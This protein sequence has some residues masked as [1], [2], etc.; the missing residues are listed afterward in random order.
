[1]YLQR[2]ELHGF[3]SFVNKVSIKLDKGITVIVGPNGSGKSNIVDSLR[4]VLGETSIKSLRG[5]KLEDVIFSGTKNRRSMGMAEV[6][7]VL[8]NSSGLYPMDYNEITVTR[9]VFRDGE[10]QFLINK[11]QCRL[12]DVQ[13]L[14]MDT[15]I[16]KNAFAIIG[17]GRVE[18]II[19]STPEERR[20]LFEE[21][22]G[23]SKYKHRK[24]EAEQKLSIT[25]QNLLRVDDIVYEIE[26][27]LPTL[28]IEAEIAAEYLK[29]N[30]LLESVEYQYL[31]L[32]EEKLQKRLDTIASNCFQ[33][34]SLIIS[35]DGF[36]AEMD[37]YIF[38]EKFILDKCQ[39]KISTIANLIGEMNSEIERYVG[40]EKVLKEK[41]NGLLRE[42]E[43][44]NTDKGS[45][46][47][48]ISNWEES[49]ET[50]RGD[51]TNVD[52][53]LLDLQ[54]KLDGINTDV[55]KLQ[56]KLEENEKNREIKNTYLV[57]YQV[58]LA[59]YKN[60]I[61]K[62]ETKISL[63]KKQRDKIAE[64]LIDR[65]SRL[66]SL[67]EEEDRASASAKDLQNNYEK[68]VE[69]IQTNKD[70]IANIETQKEQV[71][72]QKDTI[73]K[74][75]YKINSRL[76]FLKDMEKDM[77]GYF[78]GVKSILVAK[79]NNPE[80]WGGIIG[81]VADIITVPDELVLPI[82]VAIG[83]KLQNLISVSSEEAKKAITY[84]KTNKSGKVTFLP[85]DTIQGNPFEIP[86]KYKDAPGLIGM[87]HELI[88]SEDQF[89]IVIKHLLG[90][91]LIVEDLNKGLV[92]AKE[93]D[94][95]LRIA[96]LDG[97]II[98]PG[99]S[100]TG[101]FIKT[102]ANNLLSRKT[103]IAGL[104]KEKSPLE[105]ELKIKDEELNELAI[106][107][108]ELLEQDRELL[109][110]AEDLKGEMQQ[111][112][113][114][115][116]IVKEK[117]TTAEDEIFV[118][119]NELEVVNNSELENE[120]LVNDT[121]KKILE[122]EGQINDVN[123][124][125]EMLK[126]QSKEITE[127]VNDLVDIQHQVQI[128]KSVW[129]QKLKQLDEKIKDYLS[130]ISDYK[131]KVEISAKRLYDNKAEIVEIEN[132]IEHLGV[133]I[134]SLLKE[135]EIMVSI[136]QQLVESKDFLAG[137]LMLHEKAQAKI[138]GL[139]QEVSRRQHQ[140]ELEKTRI[141]TNLE[142][143]AST[144][145]EKFSGDFVPMEIEIKNYKL[146]VESLK[147]EIADLGQV[148]VGAIEH[149]QKLTERIQFLQNQKEDLLK[150][151]ETLEKVIK[152]I[153]NI[154]EEK[155]SQ[156]FAKVSQE[157]SSTFKYLFGGG[158]ASIYVTN[159]EDL[160]NTGVDIEAQPPGKKLQNITL[161][162]GGEKA[163]T[164]ISLLFAFLKVRPSPFCVLD[165]IES[166]LDEANEQRFSQFLRE[167][168]N[169]TQ[170][171]IVSHRQNTMLAADNLYGITTEEPGVSKVV[172]VKLNDANMTG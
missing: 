95:S 6:T 56:R 37:R 24:K 160:L 124:E 38:N 63:L 88:K 158:S 54:E 28:K 168:S 62:F 12:K 44:I 7:I 27:Q 19:N 77:E 17:Q 70:K 91:V 53:N 29:K 22:A 74:N 13:D 47:S 8:D 166:S 81:S 110:K 171:L 157:F 31:K 164:A 116:H 87:G 21:V 50:L 135:K 123:S 93:F 170:F 104:L 40:E 92:F 131:A 163:L 59:Q 118:Y 143:I 146:E 126:G 99:G 156:T 144:L 98:M 64:Q 9:K 121:E 133:K 101:G 119:K 41:V 33:N 105:K 142:V 161:L 151:K 15:G 141:E 36:L 34:S 26:E 155:F 57:D 150:G 75:L 94:Y 167:L 86:K 84:L 82:E 83:S 18:H 2:I 61:A 153:N 138:N 78:P 169:S 90:R 67:K 172:S 16:G 11:N 102:S 137:R 152:E 68:I 43:A 112:S 5:S 66:N 4:W 96:S 58:M 73:E 35:Y 10:S 48:E 49:V 165:E 79:R 97:Q 46:S 76:S 117:I 60:D 136:R 23:I 134:V 100:I 89:A 125:M 132:T 71:K 80:E 51:V 130:R 20:P 113:N 107:E 39:D 162:S 65:E 128:E 122:L 140:F 3:K 149:Y 114:M 129:D 115:L 69:S 145:E 42:I 109:Q 103:E 45:Q 85:L 1:L 127:Q 120:A 32:E 108:A 154:I 147:R 159:E 55:N 25:E 111:K 14:F 139:Y 52:K 30:E 72:N 106:V 148:N